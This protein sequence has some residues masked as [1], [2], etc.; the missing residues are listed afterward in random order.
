M[1]IGSFKQ[2][3]V[4]RGNFCASLSSY[5]RSDLYLLYAAVQLLFHN[6]RKEGK[7]GE[8]RKERKGEKREERRKE[9]K[10]KRKGGKKDRK[11]W[12]TMK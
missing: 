2:R 6:A 4:L 12:K 5:D 3:A 10:G 7:K 1:A 9:R 8:G 11:K